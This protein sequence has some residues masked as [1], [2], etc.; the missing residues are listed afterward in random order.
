MEDT[1]VVKELLAPAGEH[2]AIL[3]A[4]AQEIS[5]KRWLVRTPCESGQ[6]GTPFAMVRWLV[7]RPGQWPTPSAYFGLAFD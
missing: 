7:E 4:L 1:A 3:S 2:T 6:E 5:A